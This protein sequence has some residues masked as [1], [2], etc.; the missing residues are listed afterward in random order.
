MRG[1]PGLGNIAPSQSDYFQSTKGGGHGDYRNI[2]LGPAT[3]QELV[4]CMFL[5]F[6]LADQYRMTVII[7]IDGV[8]GQ[9]MEPIVFEKKKP[10]NLPA[11]DWALT[12]KPIENSESCGHCI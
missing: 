2:V 9:M 11:K 5:A 1:G 6:D 10:R 7:L 4:D 3:V 8:L 12:A